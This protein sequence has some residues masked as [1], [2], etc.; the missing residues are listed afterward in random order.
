M[1]PKPKTTQHRLYSEVK[2]QRGKQVHSSTSRPLQRGISFSRVKK[3]R[4]EANAGEAH[5]LGKGEE[6][7]LFTLFRFFLSGH[8]HR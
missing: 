4:S 7:H 3:R 1:K 2:E 8:S 6:G 5:A